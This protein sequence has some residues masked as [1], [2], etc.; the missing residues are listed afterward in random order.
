MMAAER[1]KNEVSTSRNLAINLINN[2]SNHTLSKF[3]QSL[4]AQNYN[5][6]Q[7]IPRSDQ[8]KAEFNRLF[9]FEDA[10]RYETQP[11]GYFSAVYKALDISN[12]LSTGYLNKTQ[13][14][15]SQVIDLTNMRAN[16]RYNGNVF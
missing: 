13:S 3:E 16:R 5:S 10:N 9:E 7:N 11:H 6:Y 1:L 4:H 2:K 14:N 15:K 8:F 12:N